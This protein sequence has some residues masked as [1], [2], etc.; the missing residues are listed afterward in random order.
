MPPLKLSAAIL[1]LAM[2]SACA[3]REI[4]TT[5]DTS[6]SAFRALSYAVPPKA[7]PETAENLYD[8]AETVTGIQQHNARWDAL[9]RAPEG[10]R[11]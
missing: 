7:K 6:C 11:P 10:Q 3:T 9:C 8:T 1:P 4:R 5:V 2:L